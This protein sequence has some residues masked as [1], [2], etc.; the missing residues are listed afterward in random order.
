MLPQK[1][2]T[3]ALPKSWTAV[4]RS[5]S[6]TPE[7]IIQLLREAEVLQSKGLTIPQAC[8]KIGVFDSTIIPWIVS[9][10]ST[11]QPC[12]HKFRS[13]DL[14]QR[15]QLIFCVVFTC[16]AFLSHSMFY[17]DSAQICTSPSSSKSTWMTFGLQHTGQSSIYS[18]IDPAET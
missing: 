2:P 10:C 18:W 11:P 3:I 5:K 16:V 1:P 17:L 9:S 8:K 12:E 7:R 14:D 15:I 13:R 6:Y 4:M